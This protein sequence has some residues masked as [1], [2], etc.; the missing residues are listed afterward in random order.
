MGYMLSTKRCIMCGVKLKDEGDDLWCGH[1]HTDRGTDP[2]A[3]FCPKH[4][5]RLQPKQIDKYIRPVQG[6]QHPQTC[7]GTIDRKG[8]LK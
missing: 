3:G 4:K 6:C 7:F 2:C 1:V 5:R 8:I